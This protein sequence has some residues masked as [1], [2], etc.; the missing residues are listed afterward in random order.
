MSDFKVPYTKILRIDPHPNADRL[1]LATVYGFQVVI[2]KDKYSI[3]Q[4]IVF[5]PV[6]SILDPKLE[7]KLFPE[8]SKIKLNRSRIRQIRIRQF[9]SQ[10]MIIDPSEVSDIIN[11]NKVPLE[12][13]LSSVLKISKYE[14]PEI[15]PSQT[16]GKQKHRNK[17]QDHPLFH[18]YNG[19]GNI[20][21]YPNMFQDGQQVTV[22]CKL[23]GTNARASK[24]PFVANTLWKRLKKWFGFAKE[25]ELCYGSNNVEISARR[26]Y[27]GY[28]GVDLYGETFKKMDI[29][30]KLKLGETVFGEIIGPN[31]Q[32]N[33]TYGLTENRFV[34]FDVKILQ[35]DGTQK[36]LTPIE[37]N[38]FAKDRDFEMV[39]ILYEGPYNKE[40]ISTLVSGPSV[41]CPQQKI[42]EG[43]V[44]KAWE[45]SIEGNKQALK[46]IN[47]EYLEQDTTEFH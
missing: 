20:K 8:G 34:L 27:T 29:F 43:I 10:G 18:K 24:L 26:G 14:P 4:P 40:Y 30:S 33:Y 47:P 1:S 23:H 35:P 13:D 15:G 45:Y 28:Y 21:W 38:Q 7:A 17:I 5:V 12:T 11:L 25:F 42:R 39:P 31:I 16:L 3:N 37:V 36:W 32:K 9:P 2:Q 22:Q 44:I 41:Y 46:W 19:I 6:D